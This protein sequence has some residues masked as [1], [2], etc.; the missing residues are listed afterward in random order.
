MLTA[1]AVES[2]RSVADTLDAER[3]VEAAARAEV[4]G[5]QTGLALVGERLALL[6]ERRTQARAALTSSTADRP[7]LAHRRGQR[8]IAQS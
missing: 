7:F 5:A 1:L 3:K 6:P 2:L 4:A 8:F